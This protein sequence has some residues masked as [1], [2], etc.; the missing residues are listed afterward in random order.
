MPRPR[1]RAPKQLQRPAKAPKP[2]AVGD[3]SSPEG[4]NETPSVCLMAEGCTAEQHAALMAMLT[5]IAA[6]AIAKE[7]ELVFFMASDAAGP[8]AQVRKLTAAVRST[9]TL[10]SNLRPRRAAASLH[11]RDALQN[12]HL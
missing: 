6:E 5:P 4:I 8:A 11:A 2:P 7:E 12:E 1:R 3:L 10:N 9:P